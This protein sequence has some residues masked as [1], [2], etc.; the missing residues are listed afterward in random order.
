MRADVFKTGSAALDPVSLGAGGTSE[1][2]QLGDSIAFR[3][4]LDTFFVRSLLIPSIALL[5]G[6]LNWW[7]TSAASSRRPAPVS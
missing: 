5:H 1:A 4:M 2:Q 6:P 3:V 7:P